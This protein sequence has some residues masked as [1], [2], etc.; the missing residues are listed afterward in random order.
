MTGNKSLNAAAAEK[1]EF[2]T[3]CR[4]FLPRQFTSI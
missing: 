3:Q 4:R 2:Y 1:D